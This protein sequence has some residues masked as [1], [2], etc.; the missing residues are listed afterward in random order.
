MEDL[1]INQQPLTSFVLPFG[2]KCYLHLA[3]AIAR[4]TERSFWKLYDHDLQDSKVDSAN[5]FDV[6][7]VYLNRLS[8]L[9]FVLARNEQEKLWIQDVCERDL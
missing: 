5:K 6:I 2:S 3:R 1:Q 8:D 4:R 9:L 7:G